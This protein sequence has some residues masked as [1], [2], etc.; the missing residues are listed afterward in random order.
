[1]LDRA[2]RRLAGRA[3]HGVHGGRC[4]SRSDR[5][6][7]TEAWPG[8]SGSGYGSVAEV[9]CA[10]GPHSPC[11]LLELRGRGYARR[12]LRTAEGGRHASHLPDPLARPRMQVSTEGRSYVCCL[13]PE[14]GQGS[15]STRQ[16]RISRPLYGIRPKAS[17]GLNRLRRALQNPHSLVPRPPS[18]LATTPAIG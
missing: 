14:D 17:K 8:P 10:R 7:V 2:F 18:P 5:G 15:G 4:I 16:P 1:M 9:D 6:P 12:E 3:C 13:A 11:R